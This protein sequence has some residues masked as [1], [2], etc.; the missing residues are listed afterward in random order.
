VISV[1]DGNVSVSLPAFAIT[2][3]APINSTVT[4]RWVAPTTNVDGTPITDLQGFRVF[5][6]TTSGQYSQSVYIASPT[7]T[8]A[9]IEGLTPATWYFA[10]KAISGSG[11]E[12]A[13]SSE[14]SKTL[15]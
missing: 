2:V 8:S 3:T 1:S 4:V 14:A 5:Y 7:I 15:R 10:V 6:G 13:Y 11:V 12:S 9:V